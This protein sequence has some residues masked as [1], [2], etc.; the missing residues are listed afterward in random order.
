MKTTLVKKNRYYDSVTLMRISQAISG[1]PGVKTAMIG[2]GTELNKDSLKNV[3]LYGVEVANAANTDLMIG[4]EAE[5]EKVIN[6][7][8]EEIERQ[9]DAGK[10]MKGNPAAT[11]FKS[12]EAVLRNGF[13]KNIALISVPGIYAAR[14]AKKA[15]ENGLHVF[16]F[17]D[18]VTVEEEI[19]L[20]EL[21]LEKKLLM[22]GPDCGT[23]MINGIALGFTNKVNRGNIGIVGASGTGTQQVMTLIDQMGE[24]VSQVIG[25]GGRDLSE[26][27]GGRMMSLGIRA[28]MEDPQTKVLVTVSKPPA[29]G[30]AEKMIELL[31]NGEKPAVVC[32]L[33]SADTG[34]KGNGVFVVNNLEATAR[35]AVEI[36]TPGQENNF[37]NEEFLVQIAKDLKNTLSPEQ[38][39]FRALYGGGTLADETM[40]E[41]SQDGLEIYSNIPLK[42]EAALSSPEASH[43]HTVLDLG[44]DY[45]TRGKPHPMI[46]PALRVPRLIKESLDPQT[47]I[48]L[49]DVIL[50][51]GG[52]A[53]PAGVTV[54]AVQE[55]QKQLEAVGRKVVFISVLIGTGKDPQNYAEQERKLTDA[56]VVVVN[57]NYQAV[58]LI[59]AI[60]N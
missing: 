6:L 19:E 49:V 41:L 23:A 25:T 21:A 56:G 20:K 43:N 44:D 10:E 51:Y 13:S 52:H 34:D 50:G 8:L 57:S 54:E 35:K 45:F 58:K 31:R 7:A 53:D 38:K 60:L 59:K 33:G 32:F 28:L 12:V 29:A 36:L 11:S 18:N 3:G 55:A 4:I 46:E 40:L 9:L 48:V 17:S 15:L 14:E 27:V 37:V 24:G 26:K 47:A 2:M 39:Y 16:L 22:M 5:S 30:V 1:F 42:P